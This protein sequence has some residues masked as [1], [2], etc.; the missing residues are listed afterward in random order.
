MSFEWRDFNGDDCFR[1]FHVDIVNG[2]ETEHFAFGDCERVVAKQEVTPFCRYFL[3]DG[4]L[5]G[6]AFLSFRRHLIV[7]NHAE[8]CSPRADY[9][10]ALVACPGLNFWISRNMPPPRRYP[11]RRLRNPEPF[12]S[13]RECAG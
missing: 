12:V 5:T 11:A 6:T 8:Q 4:D 3:F 1:D 9:C 13:P 7:S 2:T 10:V